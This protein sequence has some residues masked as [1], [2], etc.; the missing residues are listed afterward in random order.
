MPVAE[1]NI[2]ELRYPIE[3]YR[4]NGFRRGYD[5][6]NVLAEEAPG[7]IW[8]MKNEIGNPKAN[9]AFEDP[10]WI[11]NLSVWKDI[12]TLW[13]F[14]WKTVHKRFYDRRTE[15]FSVMKMKHFVMWNVEVGHIPDLAEADERLDY[16]NKHGDSDQAFGWSYVPEV[17]LWQQTHGA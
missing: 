5:M 2:S 1:L 10:K 15:W 9:S 3:D 12:E 7:F 8:R 14:V 16:L 11:V 13:S 4:L 17:K 6:L